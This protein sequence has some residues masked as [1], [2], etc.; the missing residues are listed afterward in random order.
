M[1]WS[2]RIVQTNF[3]VQAVLIGLAK[4]QRF[5]FQVQPQGAALQ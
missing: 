3:S 1:T 2:G 4:V 5:A